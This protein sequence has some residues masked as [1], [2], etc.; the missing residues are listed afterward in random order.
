MAR[1][2]SAVL[3]APRIGRQDKFFDLGGHS[4]TAVSLASKIRGELRAELDLR[5]FHKPRLAEM[6]EALA[7]DVGRLVSDEIETEYVGAPRK[8]QIPIKRFLLCPTKNL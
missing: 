6:V 2:W 1:L 8:P 4:L 7:P 3:D 5:I